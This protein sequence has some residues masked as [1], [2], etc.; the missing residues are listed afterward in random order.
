VHETDQVTNVKAA[1]NQRLTH[2]MG[3]LTDISTRQGAGTYCGHQ[4][5]HHSNH[6]AITVTLTLTLNSN[7]I[8]HSHTEN[9]LITIWLSLWAGVAP[10]VNP[11]VGHHSPTGGTC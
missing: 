4:S 6:D 1:Q 11:T 2:K 7:R 8:I 9:S 5:M 10:G 3:Q